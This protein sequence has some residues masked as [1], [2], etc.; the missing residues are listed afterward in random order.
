MKDYIIPQLVKYKNTDDLLTNSDKPRSL[1]DDRK[2]DISISNLLNENFVC[3]VGEPGIGKSRLVEEIKK[4]LSKDSFLSC[5]AS[6]FFTEV[7]SNEIEYCI[8]DALDEVEEYMNELDQ[9]IG[10][11]KIKTNKKH[12]DFA[13]LKVK[14][15]T[16]Y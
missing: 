10:D 2:D 9:K 12:F 11:K 5:T 3:I 6:E 1:F 4:T 15:T 7:T 16:K 14:F 13:S 8:I